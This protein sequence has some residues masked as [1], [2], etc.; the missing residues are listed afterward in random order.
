MNNI[1]KTNKKQCFLKAE[2]GINMNNIRF[3]KFLKE[4]NDTQNLLYGVVNEYTSYEYGYNEK[5][6]DVEDNN[7]I[8]YDLINNNL[9]NLLIAP[10]SSGKT[11]T[12]LKTF[13][14]YNDNIINIITVPNRAQALQV[15]Q[16]YKIP[17]IVGEKT[18]FDDYNLKKNHTFCCVYDKLKDIK[19]YIEICN[20]YGAQDKNYK[21]R[22]V[23]DEAH[24]MISSVS[25]RSKTIKEMEEVVDYIIENKR[26]T[27][28]FMTATYDILKY[29]N[30]FNNMVCFYQKDGYKANAK[31]F[32]IY[33]KNNDA[34]FDSFVYNNI[35]NRSLIRY[36]SLKRTDK[37]INKLLLEQNKNIF[38][39]NSQ[40]KTYKI[41]ELNNKIKYYNTMT[42]SI[43]NEE[44]LPSGG[45]YFFCTS[46]LDAGTN[47]VGIKGIEPEEDGS[48]NVDSVFVIP[49]IMDMQLMNIEQYFNRMRFLA[50][51]YAIILNNSKDNENK[52]V[53]NTLNEIIDFQKNRLNKNIKYFDMALKALEYKYQSEDGT[54]D[55]LSLRKELEASFQFKLS[56]GTANNQGCIYLDDNNKISYDKKLL[57]L[58]CYNLYMNQ[59]FY[60]TDKLAEELKNIF[61]IDI[62]VINID[63]TKTV[64]FDV[65]N[66]KVINRNKKIKDNNVLIEELK[67]GRINDDE[68]RSISK[69]DLFKNLQE[70]INL[71]C[72]A[73]E[74]VET[75]IS[76]DE[77]EIENIK[78]D[79]L[80]DIFKTLTISN[81][82][83]LKQLILEEKKLKN[84]VYS[85]EIT[86]NKYK[87]ILNSCYYNTIKKAL[88]LNVNIETIINKI[89]NSSED[90][91]LNDFF[92]DVQYVFNNNLYLQSSKFLA[93]PSGKEQSIVISIIGTNKRKSINDKLLTN[94]TDSLNKEFNT[95]RYTN[96]KVRNLVNKIYN[97]SSGEVRGLKLVVK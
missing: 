8:M 96:R 59:F 37:L 65:D 85:N 94:I 12:V 22:L 28:V 63:E 36:N 42:D 21:I 17:A 13:E 15:E 53:F 48:I 75:I 91:D 81:M 68:V 24:N 9:T 90:K 67:S 40:E 62:K 30:K 86:K 84:L 14:K 66:K 7:K 6:G 71:G 76:K 29:Y 41:D 44:K 77:K 55:Y 52:K 79:L 33:K 45:D 49:T 25:Y 60:F 38:F 23:I 74:A 4:Y 51:K 39:I 32:V 18:N 16:Q 35:N 72:D 83:E 34:D 46:V 58:Q 31:E 1:Y 87:N 50:N 82:N 92:I 3:S 56:D 57:F 88:K 95:K 69:T 61:N 20:I 73:N 27:V 70:I 80:K 2:R 11:W 54:I 26:G 19:T 5:I 78:K 97:V 47:I 10:T 64:E 93:G 43:I 89:I